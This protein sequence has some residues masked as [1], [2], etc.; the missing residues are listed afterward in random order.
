MARI[1][2]VKRHIVQLLAALLYNLNLPGFATG[3]IYDGP[4]KAICAPGLN[5]YS[6]PGA[7]L[8]CPIGSLSASLN[9]LDRKLPFYLVGTLLAFGA[10]F[11]RT[12]CGWACPFGM[13]QDLLDRIPL[14]KLGKNKITRRLTGLKYLML[15]VLV[16]LVPL[17]FWLL[18]DVAYPA[19]CG[20]I[21]PAGTLEAGIPLTLANQSLHMFLGPLFSW[22][23]ALLIAFIIACLFIYRPFCR[24]IC[25]LGALLSFFNRFSLLGYRVDRSRCTNCGDCVENCKMDV[26]EVSDREC[27]Q[28]GKCAMQCPSA[29][30]RFCVAGRPVTEA[31][32]RETDGGSKAP[33]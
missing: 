26:H 7:V 2:I 20:W 12:I 5:C 30:I 31:Q 21:C 9:D 1:A 17:G 18:T 8:A 14:P 27:I 15:I 28:C 16:I 33:L 32:P 22:K 10:L 25:P 23:I 3:Q 19:F 4:S 6:C 11:G 13:I 24:F 29:A